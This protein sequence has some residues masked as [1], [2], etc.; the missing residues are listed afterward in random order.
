MKNF[1][2]I[3]NY[4]IS[5]KS[6]KWQP[7]YSMR[8]TT[9]MTK[10]IILFRNF[11]NAPK[12]DL[13]YQPVKTLETIRKKK[14][15][16]AEQHART[17]TWSSAISSTTNTTHNIMG[18]IPA[19]AV[20]IRWLLASAGPCNSQACF[21]F[22]VTQVCW[23]YTPSSGLF[24]INPSGLP[25]LRQLTWDDDNVNFSIPWPRRFPQIRLRYVSM[26]TNLWA[27]RP[28]NQ[29]S[30]LDRNMGFLLLH[31]AEIDSGDYRVSNPIHTGGR[32]SFLGGEVSGVWDWPPTFIQGRGKERVEVYP[33]P[34]RL[35]VCTLKWA[36]G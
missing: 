30:I 32:G 22:R 29:R 18:L 10:L 1:R 13:P 8:R 7:S 9:G 27:R 16:A 6:A 24:E 34:I 17:K 35:H 31:S 28:R 21:T 33:S 11:A 2:K 26:V 25:R 19:L 14:W 5:R 3:P 15:L 36:H 12:M 20:K 4:Q 23:L